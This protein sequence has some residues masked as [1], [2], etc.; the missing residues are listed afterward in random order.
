MYIYCWV[1]A[2]SSSVYAVRV[3]GS[4]VRSF[5][6]RSHASAASDPPRKSFW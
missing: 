5:R 4:C 3:V 6:V 1:L 2:A